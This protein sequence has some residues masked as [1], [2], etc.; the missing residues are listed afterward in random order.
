MKRYFNIRSLLF[1]F[2]LLSF[3]TPEAQDPTNLNGRWNLIVMKKGENKM[4]NLKL[5]IHLNLFDE[6]KYSAT[7]NNIYR[8][9]YKRDEQGMIEFHEG[10]STKMAMVPEEETFKQLFFNVNQYKYKGGHLILL[11]KEK[12]YKLV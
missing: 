2:L 11:N 5:E 3:R 1:I 6:K 10:I 9:T 8:G 4:D 12:G 7:A